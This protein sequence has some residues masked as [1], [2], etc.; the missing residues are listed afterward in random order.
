MKFLS[1]MV[2]RWPKTSIYT[3]E[4]FLP[5]LSSWSAS[6]DY[7]WGSYPYLLDGC[8]SWEDYRKKVLTLPYGGFNASKCPGKIGLHQ[9]SGYYYKPVGAH[10][11]A[12][13]TS[14]FLGTVD[15]LKT[16]MGTSNVPIPPIPIPELTDHEK[17][18]TMWNKGKLNGWW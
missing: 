15:Q 10:G 18:I 14:I 5:T 1:L 13:D 4:W 3:G 7:W 16:Y 2:T 11:Y 9:I 8:L 12:V 6:Y 17:I